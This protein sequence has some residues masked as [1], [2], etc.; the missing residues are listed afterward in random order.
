M[1]SKAELFH[2][3]FLLLFFWQCPSLFYHWFTVLSVSFF[4]VNFD[5]SVKSVCVCELWGK[6]ALAQV[7]FCHGMQKLHKKLLLSPSLMNSVYTQEI[8]SSAL[9]D[10]VVH[11]AWLL[12]FMPWVGSWLLE[13]PST[14]FFEC[15]ST[16]SVSESDHPECFQSGKLP[17]PL[18]WKTQ[19]K[20]KITYC[21]CTWFLAQSDHNMEEKLNRIDYFFPFE[22]L[23]S[24]TEKSSHRGWR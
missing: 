17:L 19:N 6:A 10:R 8:T 13:L 22:W 23:N 4:P 18:K 16:P 21:R 7:P 20:P 15:K 2:C 24:L 3:S 14:K 9:T 5:F 1:L 12:I 11:C